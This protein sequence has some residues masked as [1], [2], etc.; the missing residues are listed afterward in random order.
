MK[1]AIF[2]LGYVGCVSAA[3]LADMGHHV[4]GVDVNAEKVKMISRGEAP[5]IEPGLDDCLARVLRQGYLKATTSADEA[6]QESEVSIICVGTPGQMNGRLDTRSLE[7]VMQEV[8][9]A[10]AS[11][12]GYHVVVIRSTLL[13]G[14]FLERMIPIIEAASGRRAGSDFGICVNPEFL[15]EGSAIK[16]FRCPPFIVVGELNARDGDTLVQMYQGLSAP[17]YRLTPDAAAILKYA[18]N[19]FHALKTSFANEIGTLCRQLNIDSHQV[20]DVFIQDRALNISPAYLKPGFAFGGSC[21]PKDVRALLYAA[22]HLDVRMPVLEAV[23][24]SNEVHIQRVMDVVETLGKRRVSLIGLSFKRGTDDLR[25]SPLVRLAEAL[26]GKGFAL[27]IYDTDVSLSNVFGRNREY[28]ERVLPHV[29][30]LL[31]TD[32]SSVVNDAEI[33]IVGKRFPEFVDMKGCLR[34]DQTVIDLN[35]PND[36]GPAASK[37]IV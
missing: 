10:L 22:K 26:I 14:I 21:L 35:G 9:K 2:G 5:I 11:F 33:L 24:P 4:T 36:W 32:L 30:Q 19:A 15:R 13:P 20:M 16:D 23:L 3:C 34:A 1:I 25:E 37:S 12:R 7:H 31:S 8:G 6:V 18:S 17:I 27:N 28:I 29:N